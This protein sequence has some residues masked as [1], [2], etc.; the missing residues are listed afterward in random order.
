M[1][2]MPPLTIE[3]KSSEKAGCLKEDDLTKFEAEGQKQADSLKED[4]PAK[5][6]MVLYTLDEDRRK[7]VGARYCGSPLEPDFHYVGS[8][9]ITCGECGVT[10]CQDCWSYHVYGNF[11]SYEELDQAMAGGSLP[12][13]R[14]SGR[15]CGTYTFRTSSGHG[16]S[17][18]FVFK[19][20]PAHELPPCQ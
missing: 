5:C 8:N 17:W 15:P 4:G 12:R 6:R 11:E 10:V 20:P 7:I 19:L 1:D 3:V 13:A 16:V 9:P 14:N 2:V 18:T